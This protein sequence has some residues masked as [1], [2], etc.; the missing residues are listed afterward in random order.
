MS[1]ALGMNVMVGFPMNMLISQEIIEGLTEDA[2]ERQRLMNEIAAKMVLGGH[3]HHHIPR[4]PCG[5][6]AGAPDALKKEKTAP[7]I[8]GSCF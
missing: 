4:H 3:G 8:R 2:A 6:T 5:G 1:M 7:S